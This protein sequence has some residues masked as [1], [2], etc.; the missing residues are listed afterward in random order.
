MPRRSAAAAAVRRPRPGAKPQRPSPAGSPSGPFTTDPAAPR[1]TQHVVASN[2]S[3]GSGVAVIGP[4][5]LTRPASAPFRVRASAPIRPV[6]RDPLA[7]E[8]APRCPV[9]RCLS[10]T[11]IRFSGRP[12]PAGE[13]GLPHG[14]P[15][16]QTRLDPDGVVTFRTRQIRPGWVPSVPRGRWCAPA[17]PDP[18]GRHP[19][20]HSGRPLS[21]A[22]HPIGGSAND[23]ASTR[24]HANSPV[25][26]S[27][28]C[29]PRME[30]EPLGLSPGFAPRGYPRRTPRRGRSLRT[31]PGTTPSTSAEPPSTNTAVLMRLRVARPC[32]ARTRRSG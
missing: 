16:R 28:A 17:R 22:E 9:S 30:R 2:L 27:P 15:T 24:V 25:R 31:G 18:P 29:D 23:E 5:R 13:F 3:L 19:P 14:R 4:R 26:S 8:P 1:P 10:A 20:P 32:S 6:M 12:A 21:P 11:G 7:E